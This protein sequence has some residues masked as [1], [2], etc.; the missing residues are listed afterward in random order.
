MIPVFEPFLTEAELRNVS[1]CVQTG[2]ISSQGRFIR[3]F[4]SRF[5]AYHGAKHAIAICNG[6]AALEVSLHAL[7]IGKDDEVIIPSFTII[8]VALAVVRVGAVPKFVDVDPSTWNISPDQVRSAIGPRTR[9]MIVVHGFGHP[10]DMGPLMRIA[11]KY[12]LKVIEDTAEAIASRYED[13]LCGTFGDVGSFSLYANKLITTGEGGAI[14]TNDDEQAD[15][16]RRYIN[17]YFGRT[18][19]FAHEALGYNFRMTNMQAAIGCAQ[20]DRIEDAADRKIELGHWYAAELASC[21]TVQFQQTIGPV[22]HVY[23]MYCVLL[24]D[25]VTMDAHAAMRHLSSRGVDTRSFFRGLHLQAPLQRYVQAGSCFPVTER[26]YQRGF[27][28]PSSPKLT[29]DQVKTIVAALH[30]LA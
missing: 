7:G 14:I 18:E 3:E 24:R 6:T 13:R 29:R 10:A 28:L 22:R 11:H 26:L 4:E 8:S 12:G 25:H 21:E 16:A 1:E 15:R 17:L 30:Q 23:W 9:A 19:R 20:M 5:A 2:W 27:Y